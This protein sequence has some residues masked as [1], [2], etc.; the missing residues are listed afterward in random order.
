VHEMTVQ[1]KAIV[2]AFYGAKPKLSL[3][4]GCSQGGR[5]GI[6][7]AQRYPADFDAIVAGAPAVNWM[8][9]SGVRMAINLTAHATPEGYIPPS[10]YS[11][12]HDAVLEAC[13]VQDGVKDGV[14]EDPTRCHF[15]PKVLACKGEDGPACLTK[16]QVETAQAL[17]APIKHPK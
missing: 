1:S 5:Q 15:D 6:T 13:D 11:M 17:Y 10:K 7:E 4:N 2:D 16:P 14:L 8:R 12:I 3:W 9:L